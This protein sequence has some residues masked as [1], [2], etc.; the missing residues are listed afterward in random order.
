VLEIVV[1]ESSDSGDSVEVKPTLNQVHRPKVR[2][3]WDRLSIGLLVRRGEERSGGKVLYI[4]I[5]ASKAGRPRRM[6]G[7][8][9][10][11]KGYVCSG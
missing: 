5:E 3:R 7:V 8:S 6:G 11:A 10:L 9:Q 1:D 4:G 2:Q